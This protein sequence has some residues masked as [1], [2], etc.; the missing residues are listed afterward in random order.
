MNEL[1]K[2]ILKDVVAQLKQNDSCLESKNKNVDV[3]PCAK[4]IDELTDY[5]NSLNKNSL[6]I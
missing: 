5:W 1:E 3:V 4:I 2:E 6:K